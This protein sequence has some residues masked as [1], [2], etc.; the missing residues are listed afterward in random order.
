MLAYSRS[1]G[2]FAGIDVSGGVLNPDNEADARAY[3]PDAHASDVVLGTKHVTA[4]PEADVFLRA[5]RQ[6]VRATTGRF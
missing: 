4:P 3:G 2:V 6:E 1:Q 5:L